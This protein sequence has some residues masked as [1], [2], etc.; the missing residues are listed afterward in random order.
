[1]GDLERVSL[2]DDTVQELMA[3]AMSIF[4]DIEN[5]F[6]DGSIC[7]KH[8]DMVVS[9]IS[10][11]AEISSILAGKLKGPA[12]RLGPS[13]KEKKEMSDTVM[14]WRKKEQRQFQATRDMVQSF[15]DLCYDFTGIFSLLVIL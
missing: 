3:V 13:E 7:L 5:Q 10:Q 8:L 12:E 9:H 14:R 4:N 11:F 2:L 6:N 15:V 1:M